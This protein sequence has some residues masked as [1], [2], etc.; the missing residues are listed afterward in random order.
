MIE[1]F[2]ASLVSQSLDRVVIASPGE[3][4]TQTWTLRN[5]G[6][7]PWPHKTKLFFVG[8]TLFGEDSKYLERKINP[9]EEIDI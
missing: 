5:D 9:G 2:D 4:F 3:C 7:C 1:K 8:G 6:S